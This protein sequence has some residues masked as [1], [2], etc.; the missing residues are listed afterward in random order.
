MRVRLAKRMSFS[1]S[2]ASRSETR[3]RQRGR[4]HDMLRP[5]HLAELLEL[6]I[7]EIFEV[8]GR[9]THRTDAESGLQVVDTVEI[10]QMLQRLAKRRGVVIALRLRAALRPQ[11]RRGKTW[12]EKAGNAEG[13]DQGGAG[14]VEK[15]SSAVAL[16]DRI[17]GHRRRDHFPE[18]LETPDPLF[19]RIAG[20]DCGVDGADR[21]A[22][23]P[24]RLEI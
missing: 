1:R 23:D 8:A 17:P 5:D 9:Y 2:A 18:L 6:E 20:D 19:A 21:Y 10:D 13:G 3:R 16:R 4:R 22:G 12:R 15:R 14:L 7:I 24:F 11:Q